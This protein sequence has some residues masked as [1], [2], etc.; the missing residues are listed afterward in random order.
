M[1]AVF[2]CSIQH[3]LTR[4]HL[5]RTIVRYWMGAALEESRSTRHVGYKSW[6]WW[7]WWNITLD[8]SLCKRGRKSFKS[9][10][11]SRSRMTR[12]VSSPCPQFLQW[13]RLWSWGTGNFRAGEL[14]LLMLTDGTRDQQQLIHTAQTM[15]ISLHRAECRS[16]K[17]LHC[18]ETGTS[19]QLSLL[20]PRLHPAAV[21][22]GNYKI[23]LRDNDK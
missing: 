5:T 1:F 14:G 10:L 13:A 23:I 18:Q 20:L 17:H 2:L 19:T 16:C 11:F 4:Y 7:W 15:R 12:Y 21:S 22:V 9:L 8:F 6:W 3:R